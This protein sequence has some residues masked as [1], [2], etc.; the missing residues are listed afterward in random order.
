MRDE[1]EIGR[2]ERTG[3][4]RRRRGRSGRPGI[5]Y[6][7]KYLEA[8]YFAAVCL[9]V[10]LNIMLIFR[11]QT[12]VKGINNTLSQVLDTLS[13][14][15][16]ESGDLVP[17][18]GAEADQDTDI[19]LA[20]VP[21]NLPAEDTGLSM[22][23][24]AGAD[25]VSG[26][27]LLTLEDTDYVSLCG[28]PEVDKPVKR[29]EKE[30]L[31]KLKELAEDSG[32]IE[33][34]YRHSSDYPDKMLEALANNPEMAD[35][36]AGFPESEAEASGEGLTDA[37]K[38][39]EYPLFLQ[40]DPRWGYAEYGDSS[41]IGLAGCGPACLSMALYYLLDDEELTPDKIAAYSMEKGYYMSGTGTAWALL[42]DVPALYGVEVK[43]PKASE[44]RMKKDLDMGKVIICS[45]GRGDFTAAGHFVVIYGYDEDGFLV[46]DPNCVAR[47]REKWTFEQIK[48]QI[49]HTWVLGSA[50]TGSQKSSEIFEL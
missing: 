49:K 1:R 31:A 26:G 30:V 3:V 22:Q 36:V 41:N 28:L 24:G 32:I 40:W 25:A 13:L 10:V 44:W 45:M 38:E 4:F 19:G 9:L 14:R 11:I 7:G 34:I 23:Y 12:Q 46:N 15:V 6:A 37:E 5:L 17:A 27:R 29:T 2:E 16:D 39:Q 8:M 48:G 35:F 50:D 43:Q 20:Y 47:S 18:A 33:D 21:G 42:T